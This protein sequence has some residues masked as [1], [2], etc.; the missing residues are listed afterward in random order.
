MDAGRLA[1]KAM[2]MDDAAWARHA[3]PW[4]GWSRITIL[5]LLALAV[6]SQ[7]WLGWAALVPIALV[8]L[9]AW[10]NPRLFPAP[11]STDNWMSRGVLGER[12]WLARKVEPIPQHHVRIAG[13]LS[14]ASGV[15][16]VLLAVGLWV[17][18]AGTVLAG[19]LLSMGAKLWFLD[20]M[21]WLNSERPDVTPRPASGPPG[22]P[23]SDR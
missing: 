10:A 14:V 16:V 15:G 22:P 3:N 13:I 21:V 5:P 20:R 7:V 9:W 18:D 17:L 23:P 8:L 12:V 6:W 2:G 19:L 4:S 11:R 1:E